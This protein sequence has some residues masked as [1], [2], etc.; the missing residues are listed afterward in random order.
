MPLR[1][2]MGGNPRGMFEMQETIRCV[3][4][5]YVV[6]ANGADWMQIRLLQPSFPRKYL[7]RIDD[8]L[9]RLGHPMWVR[10]MFD[11]GRNKEHVVECSPFGEPI[12]GEPPNYSMK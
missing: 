5:D 3:A 4:G 7:K 11:D 8:T 1:I 10:M 2:M 6:E 9:K 12:P